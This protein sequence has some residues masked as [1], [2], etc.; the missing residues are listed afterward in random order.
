MKSGEKIK[1]IREEKGWTQTEL[2]KRMGVALRTVQGWE[3][4]NSFPRT[5]QGRSKLAE[6]LGVPFSY[7]LDEEQDF[8]N[9]VGEQYGSRGKKQAERILTDAQA[10]LAG[11]DLT[12]EE[13]EEFLE[14]L[15]RMYLKTK[16][17]AKDKYG[18]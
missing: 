16:E 9:T 8:Y 3:L 5:E 10:Y 2:A 7:L 15:M 13:R 12:A 1:R 17:L 11:G 6:I 18:K 4:V 14:S